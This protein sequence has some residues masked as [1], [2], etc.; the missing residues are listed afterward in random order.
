M[1]MAHTTIGT[2]SLVTCT[3]K[4]RRQLIQGSH[5]TQK[6]NLSTRISSNHQMEILID[7]N[8]KI[9]TMTKIVRR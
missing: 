2:Y 6:E 5:L 3:A 4:T 1:L 8:Q 9:L 7:G